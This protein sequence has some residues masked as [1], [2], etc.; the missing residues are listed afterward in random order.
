MEPHGGLRLAWAIFG[1]A[2]FCTIVAAAGPVQT[3]D[4]LHSLPLVWQDQAGRSPVRLSDFSGK[5]V[6]LTLA[7]TE[8][9]RICPNTTYR[10]MRQIQAALKLRGIQA[11]Y[12]VVTL[13]PAN[14]TPERLAIFKSRFEG[15]DDHW[16]FL[17]AELT[18]IRRLAEAVNF[19]F[20]QVDS[21]VAHDFRIF[22]VDGSG[23]IRR[24][25]DWDQSDVKA[26][27]GA[28]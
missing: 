9:R 25:M 13:D 20:W 18:T 16:H 11:E 23:T 15:A 22:L 7:Y 28:P 17:T 12:V 24:T 2:L 26:F 21:H 8:C 3:P 4:S 27:T 19:K 14:D 5:T 6:V 1:P 10:K